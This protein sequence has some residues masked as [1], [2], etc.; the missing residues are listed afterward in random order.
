MRLYLP[1]LLSSLFEE[2][3]ILLPVGDCYHCPQNLCAGKISE[4]SDRRSNFKVVA[5]LEVLLFVNFIIYSVYCFTQMLYWSIFG[6]FTEEEESAQ[7]T[8]FLHFCRLLDFVPWALFPRGCLWVV[9]VNWREWPHLFPH[10]IKHAAHATT[11][12]GNSPASPHVQIQQLCHFHLKSSVL[13]VR[14]FF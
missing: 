1:F 8:F 9:L 2:L 7:I 5:F 3:F 6:D 13:V 14:C 10:G 12:D 11:C 4:A